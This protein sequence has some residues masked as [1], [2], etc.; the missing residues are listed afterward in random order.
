MRL[1]F[2]CDASLIPQSLHL[3][4]RQLHRDDSYI[5]SLISTEKVREVTA[6][7][8]AVTEEWFR[9]QYRTIVPRDYAPDYCEQDLHYTWDRLKGV[10]ELYAKAAE[11]GRAAIFTVNQR[12]LPKRLFTT[13]S[14]TK[15][16]IF[17]TRRSCV[18]T[19]RA[20]APWANMCWYARVASQVRCG[21]L[22]YCM[23]ASV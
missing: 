20:R 3:G 22:D 8:E 9:Q 12:Y 21:L 11:R 14:G 10:R 4:P 7:L 5:V 16:R 17:S 19:R 23:M 18:R 15:R 13:S 1:R 6:A 2:G